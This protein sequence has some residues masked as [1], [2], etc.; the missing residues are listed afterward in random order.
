MA[1]DKASKQTILLGVH[2]SGT[3]SETWAWTA[4]A[5]WTRLTP[6]HIPPGRTW[7]NM[8]YDDATQQIVLYGGQSATPTGGVLDLLSDTW[9]WDGTDWTQ[10]APA[11]SPPPTIFLPMAYDVGTQTVIGV[12]DNDPTPSTSTW[13]WD[14][15][16]WGRLTTTHNPSWP[17]QGAGIAYSTDASTMVLFG[18]VYGL[19][20]T[21]DLKTWTF[22]ANTWTAHASTPRPRS[23]PSM[24]ED[25]RGGVLMF[26]GATTGGTAYA[27]TWTWFQNA[28]HK[29]NPS[30]APRA[31]SG[32]AMAYDSTC[33]TVLLYGG[34]VSTQ[35]TAVY[36]TD[37]WAW[38]GQTWTKVG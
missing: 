25:T 34:E 6:S 23:S 9:T 7:G 31:R 35:V 12:R 27:E 26:G 8:A 19:G 24:S 22:K 11:T 17:K 18:T 29:L 37:S 10:R 16:N 28:W 3:K 13:Q 36:Y 33:G 20:V 14:G 5:G 30:R 15:T 38:D 21:T 2:Q 32:A 1:Y 4:A